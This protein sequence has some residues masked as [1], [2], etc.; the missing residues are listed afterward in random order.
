MAMIMVPGEL[1]YVA[2]P[3]LDHDPRAAAR[4]LELARRELGAAFPKKLTYRYNAGS[5]VHK[6]IAEYLQDQWQRAGIPVELEV[7]E[8][9]TLVVD[10][11]AGN[12]ELARFGN[13]ATFPNPEVEYLALFECGASFNRTRYCNPE[14]DRRLRELRSMA[15][16]VLRNRKVYEAEQLIVEDSVIVPLYVY[17]QRHLHKPYVRDLAM[18]LVDQPP[19]YRVWLDPQWQT[20]AAQAGAR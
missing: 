16:P 5:E 11:S 2:P 3:G 12:Y 19:L 13:A 4:E 7:Q 17:T 8:W 9:K 10:T 18:N 6:L 14:F 20:R 15:D 1:C